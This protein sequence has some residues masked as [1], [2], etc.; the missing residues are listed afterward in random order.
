MVGRLVCGLTAAIT[1]GLSQQYDETEID[2]LTVSSE[3][4]ELHLQL[5]AN[6]AAETWT[7]TGSQGP[8]TCI[9]N[10]GTGDLD[11]RWIRDFLPTTESAA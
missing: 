10:S 3:R 7:L 6:A 1:F 9:L 2:A 4:G 11:G 5:W 8:I